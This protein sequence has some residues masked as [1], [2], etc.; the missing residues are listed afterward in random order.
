MPLK[1]NLGVSKKIGLPDYGSLGASCNVEIELDSSLL[2]HDL[3]SFHRHVKNAYVACRQAVNDELAREQEA[4]PAGAHGSQSSAPR[5]TPA[6]GN[7]T[8]GASQ[9]QQGYIR[10]L[11]GE[12]RGLGSRRLETIVNRMFGKPLGELTSFD[13]SS[14]IDTLRSIKDGHMRLDEV[15]NG[16]AS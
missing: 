9:K 13:A 7:G 6:N 12:I 5:T 10:Q 3:E 2:Q 15:L 14:L 11:A 4:Q 16:A 1:L 8:S